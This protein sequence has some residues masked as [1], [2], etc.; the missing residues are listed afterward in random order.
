MFKMHEGKKDLATELKA[1]LDA[2]PA[3][4][5]EIIHL[6]AGLNLSASPRAYDVCLRVDLKDMDALEGYRV[7]PAHKEVVEYIKTVS[8]ASVVVDYKV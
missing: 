6:E 8:E 2:L 7:H 5:P 1:R 3:Q 4:V